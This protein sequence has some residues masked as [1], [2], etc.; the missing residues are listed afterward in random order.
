M[1][2][3][4]VLYPF[5]NNYAPYA[6]ISLTSLLENNI[7]ANGIHVFILGFSL[8]R[9]TED[10]FRRT[11]KKYDRDITFI[12][13][14]PVEDFIQGLNMPSYRGACI[15][16]AR[17]FVSRFIPDSIKRLLYLDSDTVVVGDITPL[18]DSNLKGNAVGMVCDS[19]GRDYKKVHGF[20]VDDEYY[21][22]G[23]ILYDLPKWKELKCSKRI[24]EHILSVRNQYEALDQDLINIVLKGQ[25]TKLDLK[26]N[27]QPFHLVYSPEMYLRIYGDRGYYTEE[28]IKS[29]TAAPAILHAFRYLGMFPWHR[30]SVHPCVDLFDKYRSL[31]E[32]EEFEPIELKNDPIMIRIERLLNRILPAGL[33]LRIFRFVF[34]IRMGIIERKIHKGKTYVNI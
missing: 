11:V 9:E 7:S 13:A 15:A 4:N 17:L 6:G 2:E 14:K 8:T 25:I 31:S 28:E 29:A 30:D 19:V 34:R 5:D 21:N 1:S 26:Y 16:A 24:E 22:G 23:M 20:G 33:F 32:W 3:I 10:K 12:E 27:L 18:I